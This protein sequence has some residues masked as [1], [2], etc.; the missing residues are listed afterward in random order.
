MIRLAQ[1]FGPLLLVL[2]L[3]LALLLWQA[4]SL[5]VLRPSTMALGWG[6]YGAMVL[7]AS[8]NLRKRLPFLPLLPAAW[9]LRGHLYLGWFSVLLFTLHLHWR[10]PTG[11]LEGLL[12]LLFVLVAGS[13]VLGYW[14]SRT[15]ARR[16]TSRGE[17]LIFERIP[18][19]RQDLQ[20]QVKL[21]VAEALKVT[22]SNTIGQFYRDH[23][24]AYL[25]GPR[26][27]LAHIAQSNRPRHQLARQFADLRRYL[28]D[29]E[30]GILGEIHEFVEQKLEL[31][32]HHAHQLTLKLWLFVHL[33][34]TWALLL[35]GLVHGL[36]AHGF[37][38]H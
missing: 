25:A 7:L 19:L 35:L 16:L 34:L 11:Y 38:G 33:P 27:A 8:F 1:R 9:W 29:Q 6:L 21:L 14:L 12:A 3:G 15:I 18:G 2:L 23:L 22:G 31:D 26:H 28:N 4:L 36:L 30:Q 13:G 24:A 10:W 5:A 32:Y 17:E 20:A 37:G